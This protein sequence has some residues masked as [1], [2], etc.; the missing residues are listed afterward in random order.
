[1]DGSNLKHTA[2]SP[3]R[4]LTVDSCAETNHVLINEDHS[5][6]RAHCY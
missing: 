6:G 4:I 3:G 5:K 2:H 1:M